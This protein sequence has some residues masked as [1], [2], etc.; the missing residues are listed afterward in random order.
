M[1][2]SKAAMAPAQDN[3]TPRSRSPVATPRGA[4]GDPGQFVA[5]PQLDEA[6][7]SG[8]LAVIAVA[9]KAAAP[10]VQTTSRPAEPLVKVL[11]EPRV[12]SMLTMASY[13]PLFSADMKSTSK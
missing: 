4:C 8:I 7:A 5:R 2:T 6:D 11:S 13:L 3:K 10:F 9:I 1:P 12:V